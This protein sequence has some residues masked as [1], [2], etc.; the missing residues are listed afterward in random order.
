MAGIVALLK[1][2]AVAHGREIRRLED[3]FSNHFL[4]FAALLFG[5]QPKG[6]VFLPSLV[7]FLLLVPLSADPLLGAPRERLE[8]LPLGRGQVVA[9]R[10]LALLLNPALWVAVALPVFGGKAYL[11]AMELVLLAA[12]LLILASALGH[13]LL[14]RH[15]GWNPLLRIPA[16]PGRS[17][18]LVRNNLRET[19]R[20]LDVYLALAMSLLG[21]AFRILDKGP[22]ADVGAGCALLV[23]LAMSTSAQNLFGAEGQGGMDRYR[24]LPL[25]GWDILGAKAAAFLGIILLLTLPL[26][27]IVGLAAG[28]AALAIGVHPSVAS[29]AP[30]APWR[31]ASGRS[32]GLGLVQVV[33]LFAAAILCRTWPGWTLLTTATILLGSLIVAGRKLEQGWN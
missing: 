14:G 10:G 23:V 19:F 3:A 28:S 27:P 32:A 8:L 7:G 13:R 15:P 26:S 25:R 1:A 17:G 9:V 20:R 22:T 33:A 4:V 16:L 24:L 6:N 29:R 30:S 2:L 5:L 11:P 18:F 21:T 31:F 12:L